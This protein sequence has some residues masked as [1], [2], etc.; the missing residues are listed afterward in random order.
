MNQFKSIAK[1]TAATCMAC[2]LTVNGVTYVLAQ[3]QTSVVQATNEITSVYYVPVKGLKTSAP[4]PP[5]VEA[6]NK[7]FGDK[8]KITEKA[9]GTKTITVNPQH[10]VISLLGSDYHANILKVLPEN[11]VTN[12]TYPEMQKVLVSKNFGNPETEEIDA[13]KV[14][15]FD[16]PQADKD[17]GYK[18]KVTV[19]FMDRFLGNGND[20]PTNVVLTLDESKKEEVK[21]DYSKV[22]EAMKK[23][24]TDLS[25]YS[26]ES[27][28]KLEEAK[29]AVIYDLDVTKQDRVNQMAEAIEQAILNLKEKVGVQLEDKKIY[30]VKVALWNASADRP[31]MASTSLKDTA[32]IVVKDGKAEM[33]I[34]T[35]PMTLGTIT[36]SLQE[37]KI[38]N[39]ATKE[40]TSA[41]VVARSED[42][43]PIEFKF[44]LPHTNEFVQVLV[45]PKVEIMGNQDIPARIKVDYST[46]KEV[47]TVEET[48]PNQNNQNTNTTKSNQQV[49]SPATGDT[50]STSLYVMGMVAAGAA[51][52]A[53]NTKRKNKMEG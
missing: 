9:D 20:Y 45:N 22:E 47:G 24:P 12:I 34:Y 31:S 13:P 41:E 50:T 30:E 2:M 53:F 40:Y 25:K 27:V 39:D 28:K 26:S 52:L 23:I 43:N 16:L 7:A 14:M 1:V 33:H 18:I 15:Q 42:Q 36:A 17:G 37:L 5:V 6:V 8:V 49:S 44:E 21:A 51:A 29:K 4:L 10:M 11:G 19:D 3:E 35:K 38:Q 32:K 48:K 46:L